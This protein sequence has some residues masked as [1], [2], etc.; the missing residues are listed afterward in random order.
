[1]ACSYWHAPRRG[2][3]V[4]ITSAHEPWNFRRCP[5]TLGR[6]IPRSSRAKCRIAVGSVRKVDGPVVDR[7]PDSLVAVAT[8]CRRPSSLVAGAAGGRTARRR[9]PGSETA[10]NRQAC[11]EP[12]LPLGSPRDAASAWSAALVWILRVLLRKWL[13]VKRLR[14]RRRAIRRRVAVRP[15][16]ALPSRERRAPR[17]RHSPCEASRDAHRQAARRACAAAA[18]WS[19]RSTRRR[20]RVLFS[21]AECATSTVPTSASV[22]WTTRPATSPGSHADGL[23]PCPPGAGAPAFEKIRA[24]VARE[25]DALVVIADVAKPPSEATASLVRALSDLVPVPLVVFTKADGPEKLVAGEPNDRVAMRVDRLRREALHH[26]WQPP[27][28][29]PSGRRSA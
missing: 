10:G 17:S 9:A 26:A 3:T 7:S 29:C 13:W 8:T 28:A 19:D 2:S 21:T 25:V 24:R 11:A 4:T 12:A 27:W 15:L 1:M 5:S 14:A 22:S 23:F 18:E 6:S 16:T 20:G